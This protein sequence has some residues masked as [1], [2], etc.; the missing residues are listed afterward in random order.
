MPEW[1]RTTHQFAVQNTNTLPREINDAEH[2]NFL[3][4]FSGI[5]DDTAS[6]SVSRD[7]EIHTSG[8]NVSSLFGHL[9]VAGRSGDHFDCASGRPSRCGSRTDRRVR[10][11]TCSRPRGSEFGTGRAHHRHQPLCLF[12]WPFRI[13]AVVAP[14]SYRRAVHSDSALHSSLVDLPCPPLLGDARTNV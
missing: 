5:T 8:S 9:D 3:F 2:H 7:N 12:G 1:P 13:L 11:G 6:F 14:S 10:V 4:Y